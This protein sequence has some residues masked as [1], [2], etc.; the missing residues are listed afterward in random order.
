MLLIL[1]AELQGGEATEQVLH[2]RGILHTWQLD[3]DSVRALPHDR[4]LGDTQLVHAVAKGRDVLLDRIVLT[5][6]DGRRAQGRH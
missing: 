3:V 5:L 6:A 4:W 1:Q 2:F